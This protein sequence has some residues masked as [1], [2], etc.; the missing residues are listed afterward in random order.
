MPE[1]QSHRPTPAIAFLLAAR[2]ITDASGPDLA[3]EDRRCHVLH[4][5]DQALQVGTHDSLVVAVT[6]E[7]VCAI[8]HNQPQE[9]LV[10]FDY[11]A[12]A[13][14]TRF[15]MNASSVR[16]LTGR[17]QA[18]PAHDFDALLLGNRSI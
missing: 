1:L 14:L 13:A 2:N 15:W 12:G 10:Q 5:C 17:L 6:P 4:Q 3:S 8:E 11:C 18:A 7:G 16:D 9:G